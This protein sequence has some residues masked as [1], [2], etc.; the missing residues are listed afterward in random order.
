MS[1]R[2]HFDRRVSGRLVLAVFG[3]TALV[4]GSQALWSARTSIRDRV[5]GQEFGASL[6]ND[7]MR[8]ARRR[9]PNRIKRGFRASQARLIL[10]G[11]RVRALRRGRVLRRS[12]ET[13]RTLDSSAPIPRVLLEQLSY[14][15]GNEKYAAGPEYLAAAIEAARRTPGRILECGCGLSTLVLGIEASRSGTEVV[16]L[17][18]DSYWAKRMRRTL[19]R[20]RIECVTLLH[21]PLRSYGSFIW[22]DVRRG[23]LSSGFS[24]VVCDGPP[25][26]L[27][28]RYGLLPVAHRRLQADA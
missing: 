20:H 28:G 7:L 9:V 14:G 6:F 26:E 10:L 5:N 15:W 11:L 12:L 22:Y 17:E 4:L 3:I 16:T 8:A 27:G 2:H 24:L 25:A 21:A 1:L 23:E 19:K 13:L 18:Q